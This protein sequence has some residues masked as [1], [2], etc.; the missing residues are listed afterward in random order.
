[1]PHPRFVTKREAFAIH[2]DAI[3]EFGVSF[4]VRDERLLESALAQPQAD[5]FGELLHPTI[6]DQAAAYLYHIAKN[7]PFIDGNKRTAF[8]V[9]SAF[10][11]MNGYELNFSDREAYDVVIRVAKGELEKAEL[12]ELLRAHLIQLRE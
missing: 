9:M 6:A 8:G 2:N 7:H 3:E 1:L 10:L 5:F 11:L 12:S 4:G